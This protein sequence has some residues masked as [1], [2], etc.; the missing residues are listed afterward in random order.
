[1]MK[2]F[3]LILIIP[4]I[5]ISNN[6]VESAPSNFFFISAIE[7]FS[8][9]YRFVGLSS[10]FINDEEIYVADNGGSNI[11]I[12]DLDGLPIFQF[13][14]EKGIT[15]PIDIFVYNN[16]IYI[17]EE[18]KDFIEILNMRGE[19]TGKIE[20]P[21]E[22]FA[23]GKMAV[24]EKEGFFVVDRKTLNICVFNKDGKYQYNFGGRNLFNSI[25]G[26][27]AK[28]GK[29]YVSV[30]SAEP[31]IRVFDIKGKYLTGFGHI[32]ESDQNFS[33]PSGIKIDDKGIIWVVDAF[34]HRV[35]GFN[36][37]GKKQGEFGIF[38]DPK[39]NLYFPLNVDF[40]DNTFYVI[41]KGRDRISMI[42]RVD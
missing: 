22:G 10:F 23:P 14:K 20:P 1:M 26:M 42:K 9:E 40:K 7:K 38:G 5:L 17:S 21:Y 3:L 29:I 34:R 27:D 30:M 6:K 41:E 33:M 13:G 2:R 16:Y 39:K 19:K 15:L 37:E 28:N 31:V 11:Y 8:D 25:G 12:F 24:S 4:I 18:G 32:G 35:V 36:I